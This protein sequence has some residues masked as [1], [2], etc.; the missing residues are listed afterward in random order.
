MKKTLRGV[1]PP[2]ATP[3][4]DDELDLDSLRANLRAWNGTGLCGYLILGSNG[5]TCYLSEREKDQVLEAAREVIAPDK[6]FMVGTGLESTRETIKMTRRAAE[7]GADCALVLTPAYYKGQ[8][9]PEVLSAHFRK[10]AEAATIPILLYNV[11][12]FTG[13]NM[14]A[15]LVAGLSSHPNIVGVKDSSGNI[16]QF[17]EIIRLSRPDFAVF[18]GSAPVFYP[19][20]CVG[21]SGGILAVANVIPELCVQIQRLQEAGDHQGAL[22]LQRSLNPLAALVTTGLGVGGL[23]M[24]MTMRGYRGAQVRSPLDMPLASARTIEAELAK[25]LPLLKGL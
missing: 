24:A 9:T 17:T 21:A 23:K 11:P 20:L 19:A 2:V 7:L 8:M 5:E 22:A 3:F 18:V 15:G 16:G 13:V 25:V 10:V 6:L 12:Q 14:P 4:K 1:L